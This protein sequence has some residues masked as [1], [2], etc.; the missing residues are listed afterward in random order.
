MSHRPASLQRRILVAVDY[1]PFSQ[2]ALDRAILELL[3]DPRT[4]LHVVTVAE[5][6]SPLLD[7]QSTAALDAHFLEESRDTLLDYTLDRVQAHAPGRVGE[8]RSRVRAYARIGAVASEII[9]LASEIDAD[10]V[11]TGTHG[12]RGMR[13][14]ILGSVAGDVLRRA[15]C[16]VLIVPAIADQSAA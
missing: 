3:R 8:L 4:E 9:A 5:R 14:L 2:A 16:Q 1:T 6:E 15:G 13:R 7:P 11:V 10:L 12:R